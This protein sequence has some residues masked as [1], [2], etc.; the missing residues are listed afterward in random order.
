VKRTLSSRRFIFAVWHS[1]ILLFPYLYK[2]WKG[3]VLVSA[4]RDGE[5]IAR[6]CR[7]RGLTTIRGS[8]TRGGRRALAFQIRAMRSEPRPGL[9]VPDGPQGP[10]FRVQPGIIM[11]AK[12]TGYPII[13]ITYSARRLK[14]FASWDRF[15]LP[16]PFTRCR[17]V[18]GRPVSVPA[19]ADRA[20]FEKRR[21]MLENEL[22][23]ITFSADRYFGHRIR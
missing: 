14:V 3:T 9:I 17:A 4:S 18:Y 11:L 10:R 1:R 5:Y 21:A 15:I 19:D 23:G 12:K 16:Y 8:T 22:R 6:V 2:G 13:P 7:R 20:E